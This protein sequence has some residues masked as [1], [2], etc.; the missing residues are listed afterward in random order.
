MFCWRIVGVLG[1]CGRIDS[2]ATERLGK[3]LECDG[4][5]QARVEEDSGASA[6]DPSSPREPAPTNADME[7]EVDQESSGA[8]SRGK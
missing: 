3:T 6:Q 1:L 4:D 2:A 5:K 7:V 8:S